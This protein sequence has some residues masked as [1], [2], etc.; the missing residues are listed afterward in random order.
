MVPGH[1]VVHLQGPLLLVCTA[2][3]A[4]AL[5]AGEHSD[6]DRAADRGAVSQ[7]VGKHLFAP[8]LAE[9]VE[10]LAAE[11]QQLVALSV[12][13][14]FAA[15]QAVGAIAVGGDDVEGE[16][17]PPCASQDPPGHVV[18]GCGAAAAQQFQQHQ[19]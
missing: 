6:F 2:A 11:L 7:A 19:Y 12:A 8:L 13:Q 10:A 16:P 18:R 15:D 17:G 5:G 14:F 3:F 9:G 4:A 1:D